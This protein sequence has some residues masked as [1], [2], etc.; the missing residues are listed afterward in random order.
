M[1]KILFSCQGKNYKIIEKSNRKYKHKLLLKKYEDNKLIIYTF[2]MTD[3]FNKETKWSK[4][5]CM[6]LET[7]ILENEV[8][9]KNRQ[10]FYGE[11]KYAAGAQFFKDGPIWYWKIPHKLAEKIKEKDCVS[12]YTRYGEKI[13]FIS[14]IMPLEECPIVPAEKLNKIVDDPEVLERALQ[15]YS[16]VKE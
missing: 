11:V 1:Q 3:Q 13:V 14:A 5:K 2:K 7:A 6:K 9:S 12:A 15:K 10:M 8:E 16:L 4:R